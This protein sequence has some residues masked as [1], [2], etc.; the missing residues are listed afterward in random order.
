MN[1]TSRARLQSNKR[2]FR[3]YPLLGV[4]RGTCNKGNTKGT[5]KIAKRPVYVSRTL[6]AAQKMQGRKEFQGVEKKEVVEITYK[7]LNCQT[8]KRV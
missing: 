6:I 3:K 2:K 5:I 8:V 1:E 7:R 4:R